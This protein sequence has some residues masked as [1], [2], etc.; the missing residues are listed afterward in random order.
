MKA[1]F[2]DKNGDRNDIQI[3]VTMT[4]VLIILLLLLIILSEIRDNFVETTLS[5][6]KKSCV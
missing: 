3:C 6:H 1:L 5:G 2:E 4:G